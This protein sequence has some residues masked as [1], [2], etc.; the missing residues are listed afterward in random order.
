MKGVD[1]FRSQ[2]GGNI[3]ESMGAAVPGSP[4]GP[5]PAVAHGVPSRYQGLARPKEALTIEVAKLHPDPDQP[6][7]EFDPEALAD[8]AASLKARG[9]L[10]PVRV[11]WDDAGSRWVIVAGERRY[12]AAMMAGLATLTCIEAKGTATADDLLEDQLVENCVREDLRPI[13]QARAFRALMDRRGY[14]GRQLAE[15]L[16]IS[17]MAVSRALALL[18]LSAEVQ[19][20]VERG[21]LAPSVAYEVSKLAD[22]D[23]QAEVAAR[24]VSEGLNRSEVVEAVRRATP[25]RAKGRGGKAGP[26][27]TAATIRTPGGFKV[28]VEHR[29]GLDDDA[30]RAAL[31]EA[32]AQLDRRAGAA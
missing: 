6:R 5:L 1:R 26:R 29:R 32:L 14:S 17:H 23:A 25:S 7:K 8:L 28:T 4:A 22:P 15:S 2:L 27:K 11:R 13:E 21:A 3:R 9:Q 18:D 12:R 30:I 16:S 31:V 24:V 20:H 19:G 10:Q